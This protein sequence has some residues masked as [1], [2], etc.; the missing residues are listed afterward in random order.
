DVAAMG[1]ILAP[2]ALER[3][4][5]SPGRAMSDRRERESLLR[6]GRN[7]CAQARAG[8]VALLV[9][10][11]AYFDAFRRRRAAERAE[12]SI[13][14]LAWDFDSRTPLR[15]ERGRPSLTVGKL[16]NSHADRRRSLRIHVLD[17]D[18]PMIF[19]HGREASLLYGLGWRPHRRVR[20]V[21]D[22]AH[23][24]AGSQHQKPG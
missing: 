8:R 9:D 7:C 1:M 10:S 5:S 16:L 17:W 20:F 4:R 21:Y 15:F 14:I 22:P 23:A 12:K 2:P 11:A 24:V 18:Y 6:R 13:G 3:R 19:G